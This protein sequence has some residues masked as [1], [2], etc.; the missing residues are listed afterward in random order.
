MDY[1]SIEEEIELAKQKTYINSWNIL[2]GESESYALWKVYGENYGVAIQSTN[3][4]L[5]NLI[6]GTGALCVK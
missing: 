1:N 3:Q 4:K 6:D 2:E 5:Q